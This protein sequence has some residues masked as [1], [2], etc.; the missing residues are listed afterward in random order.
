MSASI[1]PFPKKLDQNLT[2]LEK[3]M[4]RWLAELSTNPDLI[5]TVVTRMLKFIEHYASKSF[6]PIFDLPVPRD[7]SQEETQALLLSIE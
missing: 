2:E 1:I 5:E 6:E 4:R 3:I 7:L